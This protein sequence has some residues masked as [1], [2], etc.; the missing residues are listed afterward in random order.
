MDPEILNELLSPWWRP[1]TTLAVGMLVVVAGA[2]GIKLAIRFDINLW[3][4]DR[5]NAKALKERIK[6]ADNCEHVWTLYHASPFSQCNLCLAYIATST[7]L[8]FRG[9]PE[10]SLAG[11]TYS[12]MIS[13]NAGDLVVQ[14][15]LGVRHA[16]RT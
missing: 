1:M 11:Q 5:R 12:H 8:L 7:L 6:R 10:L 16:T 13:P 15:P 9:D 2:V 14:N 4:Q 3:L